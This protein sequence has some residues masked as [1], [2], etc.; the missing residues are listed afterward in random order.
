M[1][2]TNPSEG[3]TTIT[4][5]HTPVEASNLLSEQNKNNFVAFG[6]KL[7]GILMNI[8][9][10]DKEVVA[11]NSVMSPEALVNL[12]HAENS[13][14]FDFVCALGTDNPKTAENMIRR[15]KSKSPGKFQLVLA[16]QLRLHQTP[17]A[18]I[19]SWLSK[20]RV[21]VSLNT[22]DL[23]NLDAVD[24]KILDGCDPVDAQFGLLVVL[25]DNLGFYIRGVKAGY[26]QYTMIK[27]KHITKQMLETDFLPGPKDNDILS[28]PV[29]GQIDS[30]MELFD[31]LPSAEECKYLYDTFQQDSAASEIYGA[32]IPAEYGQKATPELVDAS[33]FEAAVKT[34]ILEEE[35]ERND[36][37]RPSQQLESITEDQGEDD[38]VSFD[39]TDDVPFMATNGIIASGDGSPAYGFCTLKDLDPEDYNKFGPF[40]MYMEFMK[41]SK[42]SFMRDAVWDEWVQMWRPGDK[43]EDFVLEPGDPTQAEP[44]FTEAYCAVIVYLAIMAVR[45]KMGD[46]GVSPVDVL[47]HMIDRAEEE[48]LS[49]TF[50]LDLRLT[51]IL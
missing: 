50:L 3:G 9:E 13:L 23:K 38:S 17:I 32:F 34:E 1:A 39:D 11:P 14:L 48:P 10:T 37:D 22:V 49:F 5:N 6:A 33:Q 41:K 19:I 43:A 27:I 26:D 47:D 12:A 44:E 2:Y 24:K 29:L 7:H 18:M 46:E 25:Y 16:E 8:S 45:E 51:E 35:V 4:S 15:V 20:F 42:G 40:H 36:D 28:E 30:I 31:D 21:S